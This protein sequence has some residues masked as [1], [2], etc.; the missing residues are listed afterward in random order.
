MKTA[1]QFVQEVIKTAME[2]DKGKILSHPQASLYPPFAIDRHIRN[3]TDT[4]G[5]D[6]MLKALKRVLGE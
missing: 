6:E 5:H 2:L 1:E 4:Y 3:L